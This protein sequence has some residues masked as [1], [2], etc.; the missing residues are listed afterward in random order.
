MIR[1]TLVLGVLFFSASV[2]AQTVTYGWE[3]GATTLGNYGDI[4]A[5]NV[6]LIDPHT[7]DY[8]PIHSG[9]HSLKLIDQAESGT[10]QAF[11]ALIT[12][13]N[14]GDTVDASFWRYDDTSGSAP[15]A[16][17]WAHYITDAND[18]D[19]Y[20]GSAGGNYDYGDGLG[21]DE[22]SHTWTFDSDGGNRVGLVLEVRTYSKPG[23]TIW[24]DDLSVTSGDHAT[25][26]TPA[27]AV[28]VPAAVWLFASS[29]L[30]F[31]GFSRRR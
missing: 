15:S 24:I 3:D 19:S 2:S 21:W 11:V 16:R 4:E 9:D 13:L 12:D 14:D 29:L 10:P 27:A 26:V 1:S 8:S 30:G 22:A 6:G 18:I 31:F 25:I 23:D 7:N 28:P 5:Y 20:G 17:I